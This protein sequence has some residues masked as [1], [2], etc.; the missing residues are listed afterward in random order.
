[1]NNNGTRLIEAVQAGDLREVRYCVAFGVDAKSANTALRHAVLAG[2][3]DFVKLVLPVAT[4]KANRSRAL[5]L[6]C[7]TQNIEIVDLLLSVFS[8]KESKKVLSALQSRQFFDASSLLEK[9]IAHLEKD[10][11][12]QNIQSKNHHA[13]KK[14][15]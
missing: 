7:S 10:V 3:A 6:A 1:M 13:A 14:K 12:L 4:S 5:M 2:R 15:M 8:L 11:L 9:K